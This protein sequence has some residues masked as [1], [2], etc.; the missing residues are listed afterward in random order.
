MTSDEVLAC[1]KRQPFQLFRIRLNSGNTY[2]IRHPEMVSVGKR[3]V[4]NFPFVTN[5]LKV[6]E[7]WQ[8]SFVDTH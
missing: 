1:V 5:S 7:T 3:D 8:K 2:E 4:M 6:Y